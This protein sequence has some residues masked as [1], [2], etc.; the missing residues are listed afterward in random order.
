MTGS[1]FCLLVLE[2]LELDLPS[3]ALPELSLEVSSSA[4]PPTGGE[5]LPEPGPPDWSLLVLG[6]K[7]GAPPARLP[8]M[9]GSLGLAR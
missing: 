5:E 7:A 3:M 4:G 2:N 6:T 1:E 9:K 8:V